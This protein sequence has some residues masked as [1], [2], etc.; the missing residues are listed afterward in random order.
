MNYDTKSKNN[1]KTEIIIK[2]RL[3]VEV[4]LKI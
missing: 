1:V 2:K 3:K 4:K